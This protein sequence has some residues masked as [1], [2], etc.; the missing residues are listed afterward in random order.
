MSGQAEPN[1]L[2]FLLQHDILAEFGWREMFFRKKV[3]L[4]KFTR[5]MYSSQAN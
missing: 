3:Q 5:K 2:P 1:L 4:L